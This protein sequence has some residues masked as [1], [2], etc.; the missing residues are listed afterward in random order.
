MQGAEVDAQGNVIAAGELLIEGWRYHY[1]FRNEKF[2]PTNIALPGAEVK[3]IHEIQ[4]D[5]GFHPWLR[6]HIRAVLAF[7]LQ[8]GEN[9]L[10]SIITTEDYDFAVIHDP[11]YKNMYVGIV[12]GST[13]YSGLLEQ[14]GL[15]K[16]G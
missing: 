7:T 2:H 5:S 8:N 1:L 6:D 10:G 14:C 4:G 13:D 3:W 9:W 16:A 11:G 15:L 12:D